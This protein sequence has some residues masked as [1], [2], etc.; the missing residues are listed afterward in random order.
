MAGAAPQPPSAG[1]VEVSIARA[2]DALDR[3]GVCGVDIVALPEAFAATGVALEEW[4]NCFEAVPG[5]SSE[6]CMAKAREHSMYVICPVFEQT[7][8]GVYNTAVLIDRD[9][10]IVGRYCKLHPT[11][12]ELEVGILPGHE[13]PVFETDFGRIGVMICFDLFY[14]E[15]AARLA[16]A[17]AEVM[18]WCSVYD[19]GFPLWAR[20]YDHSA[21]VVSAQ[22]LGRNYVI[23][24][25][26]R[27]VSEAG[28]YHNVA[29]AEVDLEEEMFCTDY[30]HGKC[31]EIM[32]RY[33]ARVEM[34]FMQ[35]EG[36]FSMRSLDDDVTVPEIIEE[37]GL[38]P[39]RDFLRRS[40]EAL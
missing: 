5:P 34:R 7:E 37:F 38:E 28:T 33:E 11:L 4:H 26:G 15:V 17:G 32:R 1:D 36:I 8:G 24:K 16:E 25:L 14:P 22:T 9:G 21:Y 12:G 10:E 39:L 30:N 31:D 35:P 18:F 40:E 2:A 27:T 20:A 19:G 29:W 23:D 6:M 3:A 13:A